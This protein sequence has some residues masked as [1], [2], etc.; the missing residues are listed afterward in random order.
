[1]FKSQQYRARATACGGLV[2]GSTSAEES[3]DFK[4]WRAGF[5]LLTDD[6]R[7][8]AEDCDEPVHIAEQDRSCEAALTADEEH[9]LR[10]L[11]AALIMQ[12]NALPTMLQ[13]EIFDAAGS[14]GRL[15][16]TAVLRGQ[17]ARF[18][19]RHKDDAVRGKLPLTRGT[20]NDARWGAAAL[21]R[22]DNEGGAVRGKLRM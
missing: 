2:K 7:G 19:H 14:V 11:G 3:R 4:T 9:I 8:F 22:W 6:K 16:E 1:M 12:W 20:P 15:V 10:C 21:S 18:L 5:D 13:R 17:I